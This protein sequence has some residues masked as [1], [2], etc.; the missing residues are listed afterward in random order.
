LDK[1]FEDLQIAG[2]QHG[3]RGGLGCGRGGRD[4]CG[5]CPAAEYQG[6]ACGR[7]DRGEHVIGVGVLEEVAVQTRAEAANHGHVVGMH[8]EHDHAQPVDLDA[9]AS[10]EGVN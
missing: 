8:R 6:S 7:V 9:V 2:V 1:Q 4:D 3:E 10:A 5:L